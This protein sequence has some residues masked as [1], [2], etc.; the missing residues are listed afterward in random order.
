MLFLPTPFPAF[1][2]APVL[3]FGEPGLEKD[4]IAALIHFGGPDHDKPM[5]QVN[6]PPW[7]GG[8]HDKFMVQVSHPPWGGRP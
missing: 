4:N 6:H 7:G 1:C 2:R 3:I 8:A 5:V